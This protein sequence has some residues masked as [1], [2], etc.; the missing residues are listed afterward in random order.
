MP[1]PRLR[2]T[3]LR[4]RRAVASLALAGLV[5]AGLV[6]AEAA[7]RS[8]L[9]ASCSGT[10]GVTVVVDFTALGGGSRVECAPGDPA[11]GLAALT[12][13]GFSYSFV[14]RSPGLVCRIDALP[15]PCNGAPVAAYWSYWHAPSG[16]SWTYSTV[17]AGSYDPAPGTVQG[18]AFGAGSPP[19]TSPP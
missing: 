8:A 2:R 16:G 13:A 5:A 6:V 3:P 1:A 9:A 15:N 18:W 14:P 17:G 12:G 11:S 19:G 7:P 10:S 4:L